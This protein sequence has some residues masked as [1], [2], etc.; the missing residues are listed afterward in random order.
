LLDADHH[1]HLN[2]AIRELIAT[3][4]DEDDLT[5]APAGGGQEGGAEEKGKSSSH[6]DLPVLR[7]LPPDWP[8]T[9]ILCIAGRGPF[10]GAA[11]MMLET[12]L[13]KHGL[14]CRR[15][16]DSAVSSS[17]IVHLNSAGV[18]IVCLSY[19]DLGS[20]PT[21][22]RH[23]I[24]RIRKQVPG[25]ALVVGLWGTRIC[26]ILSGYQ[27]LRPQINTF[28]LCEKRYG[29]A[30]ARF[31]P[32]ATNPKRRA[33]RNRVR[34]LPELYPE[35]ASLSRRLDNKTKPRHGHPAGLRPAT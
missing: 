26:P 2:E 34:L 27:R 18:K 21:H 4:G 14:G 10:D 31:Q 9:P 20:S 19:L 35:A 12:L 11:A 1:E 5:P 22:L 32:P 24:R 30:L 17:N 8:T 25:A 3:T 16:A 15:E 7:D 33:T 29:F 28:S 13:A 23:S 6:P